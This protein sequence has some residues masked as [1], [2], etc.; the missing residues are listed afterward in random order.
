MNFSVQ[1]QILSHSLT[2]YWNI[3]KLYN[4]FT[5]AQISHNYDLKYPTS[6]SL[7]LTWSSSYESSS[8]KAPVPQA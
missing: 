6:E 8:S 2:E 1:K 5:L 7:P 4:Y 3:T